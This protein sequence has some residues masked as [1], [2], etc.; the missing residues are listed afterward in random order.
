MSLLIFSSIILIGCSRE[1]APKNQESIYSQIVST[2]KKV[3]WNLSGAVMPIPEY[4]SQD[5][6]GSEKTSALI[7]YQTDTQVQIT[8]EM[9]GLR[10]N[11]SYSVITA[12]GYIPKTAYPGPFSSEIK[13]F[14]FMT[15]TGGECLWTFIMFSDDFGSS[16]KYRLSIWINEATSNETVLISD[17]I[18]ISIK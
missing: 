16:G 3:M 10:K 4:G 13:P 15:D 14:T 1:Q 9:S 11:T 5:M 2:I 8:G 6:S 7:V 18:D 17:N 12:K